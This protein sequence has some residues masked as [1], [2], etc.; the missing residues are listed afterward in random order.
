MYTDEEMLKG[1]CRRNIFR[2]LTRK[3][4]E[5]GLKLILNRAGQNI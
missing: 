2:L 4:K 5:V 3:E 1:L